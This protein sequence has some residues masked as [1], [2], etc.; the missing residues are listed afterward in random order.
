MVWHKGF[1]ITGVINTTTFDTGLESSEKEPKTLLSILI[2]HSDIAGNDVEGWIEKTR[3]F[4]IPDSLIDTTDRESDALM[5]KSAQRINEIP[6]NVQ[7][8]AG[9][10]FIVGVK[11][12]A[13]ASNL[14][15]AYVY[16][17]TGA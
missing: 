15:G 12:G 16:E 4:N 14:I 7:L 3:I 6:V 11:C 2:Q 1:R 8:A 17:I 10:R 5:N 13:T 9:E